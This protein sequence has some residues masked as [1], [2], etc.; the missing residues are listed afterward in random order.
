MR[1]QTAS[2]YRGLLLLGAPDCTDEETI[3]QVEHVHLIADNKN[4]QTLT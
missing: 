3:L 2:A 1:K 4:Q